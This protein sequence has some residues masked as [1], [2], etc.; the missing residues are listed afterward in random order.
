MLVKIGSTCRIEVLNSMHQLG[1]N[2]V[3]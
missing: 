2:N 3:L 1:Y